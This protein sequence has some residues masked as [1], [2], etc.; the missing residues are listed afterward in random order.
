VSSMQ[1]VREAGHLKPTTDPIDVHGTTLAAIQALH[2]KLREQSER[3]D[4]LEAE[5][6]RLRA[7]VCAP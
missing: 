7:R 1:L 6:R 3:L 5:N 4:R 2:E